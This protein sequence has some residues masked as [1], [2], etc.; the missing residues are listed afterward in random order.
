MIH[1]PEDG[2]R[3]VPLP[4]KQHMTNDATELLHAYV[5]VL[6]LAEDH[7]QN[8]AKTLERF[9]PYDDVVAEVTKVF[10]SAGKHIDAAAVALFFALFGKPDDK[11]GLDTNIVS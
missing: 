9:D 1:T 6:K 4:Y 11:G 8:V 2:I 7:A 5:A 3:T 10:D